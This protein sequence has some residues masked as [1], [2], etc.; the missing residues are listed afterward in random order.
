MR[1]RP[2][3]ASPIDTEK[4]AAAYRSAGAAAAKLALDAPRC[5]GAFRRCGAQRSRGAE[6]QRF[7]QQILWLDTAHQAFTDAGTCRQSARGRTPAA[8]RPSH[9][10][11][12]EPAKRAAPAPSGR[13]RPTDR[14]AESS[15]GRIDRREVSASVAARQTSPARGR[16]LGRGRRARAGRACPPTGAGFPRVVTERCRPR[17][18][19]PAGARDVDLRRNIP[20]RPLVRCLGALARMPAD[21]GT[22]D[23]M[24]WVAAGGHD[25]V[26][27]SPSRR[28]C[29]GRRRPRDSG[30]RARRSSGDGAPLRVRRRRHGPSGPGRR[31]ELAMRRWGRLG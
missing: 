17:V 13:P 22:S 12:F 8:G 5:T 14:S 1:P 29:P 20:V 26:A 24:K 4:A 6:R 27:G 15:S 16:K 28:Q 2:P 7:H 11:D 31:I 25:G 30:A 18:G 10:G 9:R 19:D 3:D 23:A 21:A